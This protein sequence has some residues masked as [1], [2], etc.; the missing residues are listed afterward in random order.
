LIKIRELL[1]GIF[2][3]YVIL[4]SEL[5]IMKKIS[6][7]DREFLIECLATGSHIPEDFKE[8]LFPTIQKE[9]E[10]QYDGKMRK[11]DLLSDQDGTFAVPLQ[12][13]KNYNGER[14]KFKDGWRNMI[15]FGDN[16]QFLKTLFKN[17]DPLVK[18]KVKGK[19]KL[20]YIDPP[21]ATDSDFK[22]TQGQ[23]A[24]VDKTKGSDFIEYLR[25]RLLIAK[26][27]LADNG[28]IYVHIDSKKGHPIKVVMDE[29]FTGF[30]F[31]EII[32]VCGLMGSGK[33]YPKAHET[34]FCY[35]KVDSTFNPPAR[36]GYS[37]RITNALTKDSKGWFYTRGKESSGGSTYLKT[38]ISENP[39]LTKEQAINDANKKRPQSA[40]DVWM[41]KEELAEYFNDYPVGTYA[42][43]EDENI[44]YPTQ[45]PEKLLERI[46][47]ASS[48]ENDI[49]LDF[50][51]GSGTTAAVA[52]KLNRRWITC[53]IGKY[54]FYTI[55]K[56][57]L[58]IQDSK[59][60]S[61][62][63]ARHKS[64]AKNFVTVN[65]GIYDL[66]KMQE[67]NQDKYIEFVLQLFEVT[68]KIQKIKGIV[69]HGE[70][71]DGYSVLVWEYWNFKDSSVDSY[72]LEQLHNNIGK[73]ISKRLYIIAPANAVHFIS[74]FHEIDDVRYYFLKIP[75]QIIRELH[76]KS[77]AKFRQ[78]Q[79]R[80]KINDL[81][82]A[83]G[84]HFSLQPEV[85]SQFKNGKI[86]IKKFL[87][88]FKEEETNR[89][90]PNFESLSMIIV[91]EDHN[92]K[93]F[94]MS[95][96][97]FKDDIEMKNGSLHIPLKK[98]G[99]KIFIIYIDLYGNEFKEEILTK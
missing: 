49:V 63:K 8:K 29:I 62:P 50:F 13:E 93:D 40:W 24:Y 37:K 16:L 19:I 81:D 96:C 73:R 59:D 77:F 35:K 28:S 97:L 36:L 56:R 30:Q 20:I 1:A 70:R 94:M 17:E 79:S 51:G 80:N 86:I 48:D 43:T 69:V 22:N 7:Q 98:F 44:G 14:K 90:L 75:Y 27:I 31:A 57:L 23:L 92:G 42:Y 74:D 76:P 32:W 82:N 2:D 10:I 33:F 67:L 55:Q 87:S 25:R 41:G 54:S 89:Q 26:E 58:S 15:V 34:I 95:L 12:I 61:D 9:Y 60:L 72:F 5:L 68:P 4:K 91:D 47:R 99:K 65:T 53:D 64:I 88:N 71:K 38:Y 52:E 39:K 46:I 18:N 45:K 21:F 83:I 6:S 66:K 84:F 78:P 3:I 85:E 11:E